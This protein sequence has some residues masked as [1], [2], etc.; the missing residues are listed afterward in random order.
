MEE[1]IEKLKKSKYSVDV[2]SVREDVMQQNISNINDNY[3]IKFDTYV[4][5]ILSKKFCVKRKINSWIKLPKL[6]RKS[7]SLVNSILHPFRVNAGRLVV[8][9]ANVNNIIKLLQSTNKNYDIIISCSA[10]FGLHVIARNLLNVYKN[11]KWYPICL[12]PFVYNYT[13]SQK[14]LNL[15]YRK[16]VAEKYFEFAEKIFVQRGIRDENMR[17]GYN[18]NYHNKIIDISLPNLKDRT[19]NNNLNNIKINLTYAGYFYRD[20]RNPD[21]MLEMLSKLDDNY[22]INLVGDGCEDIV[23]SKSFTKSQLKKFGKL[24][25]DECDEILD[26]SNI[27]INLSNT[28]TNQ[29]PSKVFEYIGFGKPIINFYFSENDT[30]LYYLK[31]YP[32]SFNINLNDINEKVIHELDKFCKKNKNRSLTFKES[33]QKLQDEVSERVV[34]LICDSIIVE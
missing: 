14:K 18:P 32:L 10:P 1:I 34:S 33:T 29:L 30:S 6:F 11:A 24:S 4:S 27:L 22:V 28:I 26:N 23:N 16:K 7:I 2:L 9:T 15:K 21:Q 12:D 20:I 13:K 8:D 25:K 5:K 19:K 31:K 17:K 3:I